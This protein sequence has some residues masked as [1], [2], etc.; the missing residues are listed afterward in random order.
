VIPINPSH[1][2]AVKGLIAFADIDVVRA[3]LEVLSAFNNRYYQATTGGE[4][5]D[6]IYQQ[7]LAIARN[8][9][10]VTVEKFAHS[11]VQPS[12]IARIPGSLSDATVI[13]GAHQDSINGASPQNGRA[14][15]ADDDGSG[16]MTIL[17]VFR[18]I[19]IGGFRPERTVE[20]QWYAA[21]EVGLRGSQA[22][23]QS[24]VA[25]GRNL[26]SQM[27]IDMDGYFEGDEAVAVVTDY[28][29]SAMNAWTRTLVDEYLAIPWINTRCGYG[30]S[31]HASWDALGVPASFPF[32]A[33]FGDI[34]PFIHTANDLITRV[35][36]DHVAE[37]LKLG[38]AY[39]VETS[40]EE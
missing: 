37:W 31:D 9:T 21:E 3:N 25:A 22:I 38:I 33:D 20:F 30:C 35:D 23:A 11:W 39:V 1:Q 19:I 2:D 15:G 36:F 6:W 32:E 10:G 17:E 34:N 7:A 16:S 8:R 27:Q 13:L 28:T 29:D 24:Y 14:P 5:A 18:A 12:V 40:F 26:V 4:S